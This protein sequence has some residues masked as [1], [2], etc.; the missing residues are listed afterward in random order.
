LQHF[1]QEGLTQLK[2]QQ[3]LVSAR[4]SEVVECSVVKSRVPPSEF[5]LDC[6]LAFAQ[7]TCTVCGLWVLYATLL[8]QCKGEFFNLFDPTSSLVL[9]RAEFLKNDYNELL[10]LK[11]LFQDLE[12]V[13][14]DLK[15]A[16]LTPTSFFFFD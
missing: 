1:R 7:A 12:S 2:R 14:R 6:E 15:R 8:G 3:D 16:S 13:F 5:P 10:S 9:E 11:N 4:V